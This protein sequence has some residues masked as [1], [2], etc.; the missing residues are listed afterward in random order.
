MERS[1]AALLALKYK[2][3]VGELGILGELDEI[4]DKRSDRAISAVRV[5]RAVCATSATSATSESATITNEELRS[6]QQSFSKSLRSRMHKPNQ[7]N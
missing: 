1:V 2:I 4:G 6:A 5:I 3:P 7:A